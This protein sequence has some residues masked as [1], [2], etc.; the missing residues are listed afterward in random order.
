MLLS[1]REFFVKK[2]MQLE[3]KIRHLESETLTDFESNQIFTQ[4]KM[5]LAD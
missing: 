4:M 1:E 3:E 5:L 2:I